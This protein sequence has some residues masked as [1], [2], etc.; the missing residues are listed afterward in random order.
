MCASAEPLSKCQVPTGLVRTGEALKG[1]PEERKNSEALLE[2]DRSALS[3]F[4]WCLAGLDPKTTKV[5][6]IFY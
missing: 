5:K 1:D 6:E 3:F 2:N 4:A